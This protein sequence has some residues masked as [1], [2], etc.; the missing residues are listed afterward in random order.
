MSS[1][2]SEACFFRR[3]CFFYGLSEMNKT[4]GEIVQILSENHTQV[5]FVVEKNVVEYNLV[6]R[7]CGMSVSKNQLSTFSQ[8]CLSDLCF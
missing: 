5:K 8:S 7:P 6:E 3:P 4:E 2:A 1:E